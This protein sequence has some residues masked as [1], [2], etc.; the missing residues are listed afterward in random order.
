MKRK[1]WA[2]LIIFLLAANIAAAQGIEIIVSPITYMEKRGSNFVNGTYSRDIAVDIA[3]RIDRFYNVRID[4]TQL[5]DRLAGTTA[6]DA[7]RAAEYYRAEYVIYGAVRNDGNS[8]AAELNIYNRRNEEHGLI[9][10]SDTANNYERLVNTLGRNIQE[11]FRT[12][13][14]KLDTLRNEVR[15]LRTEIDLL[16]DEE[17]STGRNRERAERKPD[18]EIVKEFSLKIPVSLGY[19][20]YTEREWSETIQGTVELT[21]GIQMHPELQFP[22][23]FGMKNE[24]SIDL[25]IGYRNGVTGLRDYALMNGIMISPSVGYHINVYTKNWLC[26]GAG[27][28]YE[29]GMWE[30]EE[31][32]Y[33]GKE[34]YRQSLTGY[35]ISI[36]YAYRVNR[37]FAVNFGANM[38]GYFTLESSPVIRTYLGTVITVLGGKE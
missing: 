29:L 15:D 4:R 34:S 36:D 12:D 32:E 13:T 9:Y 18:E 30:I 8:L 22:S 3:A 35:V 24:L 37:N 14:D 26:A 33:G 27:V 11:W 2:A 20:S 38:Y 17:K 28:F 10:A 23:L 5:N 1:F 31:R 6:A 19:W 7:R 16:R 21:T 25:L